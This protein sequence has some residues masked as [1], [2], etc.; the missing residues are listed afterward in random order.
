MGIWLVFRRPFVAIALLSLAACQD[1]PL[2]TAPSAPDASL[3]PAAAEGRG[4]FER[5]SPEV[6]ALPGTVFAARDDATGEFVFGVERPDVIPEVQ[7]VMG[8]AGFAPSAYRAEVTEPIRFLSETLQTEHPSTQGGIQ[9][10]FS[11]YLCTLG[12]NVDHGEGRSFFTNSHC[13][14]QQGS[15]SGTVYYQP[16]SSVNSSAI[17][18]EAH[19]PAYSKSLPGCSP[20]KRCRYSDAAR[21]A[22]QPGVGSLGQIARTTGVNSGSLDVSGSFDITAQDAGNDNFEGT[23]HKVGRTTGWTSGEIGSSCATVNVFG[24]NIQLLCQT[25]VHKADA[26]DTPIAAGGDSGSPVFKDKGGDTAELVGILWGGSGTDT[27]IFSPLA[28]FLQD[29]L[30]NFDATTDGAA[31]P[32]QE[33]ESGTVAGTVTDADGGAPIEGAAV[34]VEGTS[35]SALTDGA[36]AYSLEV[37]PGTH[38]VTASAA[39]YTSQTTSGVEVTDGSSTTLDFALSAESGSEPDPVGTVHVASIGYTTHGGRFGDRHLTVGVSLV[40]GTGA[41][42]ANASVSIEL[43]RDGS[44]YGTAS[45]TTGSGGSASFSFNNAPSGT[46]ETVVTAVTAAGMEWDEVTPPNSFTKP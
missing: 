13:T 38:S 42:V 17:G 3:V 10:H 11:N 44:S 41:P 46:Y 40:D 12:F 43:S 28:N 1:S 39:G 21:V 5:F 27:F 2:A 30:G 45:G 6:M 4:A 31:S 33:E 22:Y 16:S 24:S 26:G 36:G 32:P 14:D 19:D 35:L 20:N 15:N 8:R 18:I 37:P 34:A 7:R 29:G 9:I 23:V 25:F